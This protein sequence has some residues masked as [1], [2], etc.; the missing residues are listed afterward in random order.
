MTDEF[1]SEFADYHRGAL[2]YHAGDTASA[3]RAWQS[4]LD[5]AP[6]ER[7]YRTSWAEYMLG[8]MALESDNADEARRHFHQLRDEVK[9]GSVDSLGLAVASIGWEA[10]IELK[11]QHFA[12]AARLY[13]E[14]R[15]AGDPTAASS[16]HVLMN[17]LS[18]AQPD[19]AAAMADPLLQRLTTA[20]ELCGIGAEEGFTETNEQ[21][22]GGSK[23]LQLLEKANAR[24]VKDAD[25]VAWM[26]YQKGDYKAAE[27]WL[28][29]TVTDS[30]YALW[31]RAKLAL[32][33][34][35]IDMA[36]HLLSRALPK[37]PPEDHLEMRSLEF[38]TMP[39]DMSKGDLGSLHVG[40]ADF[41]T[42]AKL[43]VQVRNCDDATYLAEGVLTLP[44]LKKFVDELPEKS[45]QANESADQDDRKTF[46]E[47]IGR[48]L[49]RAGN[50]GEARQYFDENEQKAL[51]E[52]VEVLK[53][54]NDTHIPKA[55]RADAL[56][57]AA[58]LI[59]D[60][61]GHN[62]FDYALP[63][64]TAG[65][66]A[67]R[68]VQEP[69]VAFSAAKISYGGPIKF[70]PP[71]TTAEKQRLKS[72]IVPAVHHYHADYIAADLAWRAAQLMPDNNEETAKVLNTAGSWLKKNDDKGAD[73]FYQAIERRCAKTELGQ[74]AIKRHWF[75]PN[76]AETGPDQ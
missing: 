69:E 65:R 50:L 72:N 20:A 38:E 71:V 26:E 45:K 12:E 59:A 18:K 13:L 37:L 3:Q 21:Q 34:G 55:E 60:H 63:S 49:A 27:H 44:E 1:P 8:K 4:L 10:Q 56:W 48:R 51:D 74:Q 47:I 25:C 23:W 54:G 42:A 5:R 52:Y 17:E 36:A 19:L 66:L 33:D 43:F 7:K 35:K 6:A 53:K 39:T 58:Q 73:K 11:A 46:R 14:Q 2:A 9:Q 62:F 30:P 76:E 67:G 61:N 32:R 22:N 64:T 28:K 31:L 29:L 16:L 70:V 75:V 40:R 57:K 41:I 15:A 24:E 68:E